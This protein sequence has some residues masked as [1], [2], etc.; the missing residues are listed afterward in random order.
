MKRYVVLLATLWLMAAGVCAQ[1]DQASLERLKNFAQNMLAYNHN[2]TQEKVYLHL[3]NNGYLPGETIWFKAYVMKASSLLPTDMSKVLYVEL[4]NPDGQLIERKTLPVTNGRTYGDFKVDPGLCRPGYYEVRAYTRAMLNWDDAYVFS[5]VVPMYIEPNDTINFSDIKMPPQLYAKT[6]K[7]GLRTEPKALVDDNVITS[8]AALLSFYPEGGHITRG[9][10][11]RVAYKL[12]DRDGLPGP[13]EISICNQAGEEVLKSA[14]FHD[15]MGVFELP[16]TWQ[17][18]TARLLDN[19]DKEHIFDLPTPRPEGADVHVTCTPNDGLTIKILSTESLQGTIAG[20]SVTCRANLL[21]FS[22]LTL[23][24]EN[25]INIP[26]QKLRDGILQISLFT[27]EGKVLSERLVWCA[28][29]ST[30]PTMKI[31]QNQEIYAPFSPVVLDISLNDAEGKPLRGDFSLSVRDA[32]TEFAPEGN[33]MQIEMLM[34]SDLKGYIHKPEFYFEADDATHSQA[35]DL[36]LMVQGWRR[37][38]WQEMAGVKPFELKQPMEDGL[39]FF[40]NVTDT[41]AAGSNLAKDNGLNLNFLITQGGKAKTYDAKTKPDGTFA[42]RLPDF[43]GDCPSVITITNAKDKRVYTNL[44]INR[45]FSPDIKPYEPLTIASLTETQGER[46]LSQAKP[47]LFNW[48][49]TIPD[50]MAN[51]INLKMVTIHGDRV[52]YGY[53][54]G[55]RFSRGYKEEDV[56]KISRFYYNLREELDKYQDEGRDVPTVYEWLAE[57][58]PLFEWHNDTDAGLNDLNPST[59]VKPRFYYR[60]VPVNFIKDGDKKDEGR[61][62]DIHT[63]G[64]LMNEFSSLVIVE[65]DQAIE[66]IYK[67]NNNA[68][69]VTDVMSSANGEAIHGA[70]MFLYSKNDIVQAPYYKRGTRWLTLHGYSRCDEFYSPDYRKSEP[71]TDTDHRRTLYWNPSLTTD[72]SGKANVIFYSN[73][74]HAQRLNINAQ[75]IAVNGQMFEHNTRK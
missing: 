72:E 58:N 10:P 53:R 8:K 22:D 70:T 46:I 41:Q 19:N 34:A 67:G 28:P 32:A 16:D 4:L 68:N 39:L 71:K 3:D 29:H 40:G 38:S 26:Y 25:S 1:D 45:N 30:Q 11:T 20:L 27:P 75:G 50:L 17:G 60:G 5:R 64:Y 66:N 13:S 36:L 59:I 57:V 35:L 44:K 31:A 37:Y 12:T 15:G 55:L 52:Q 7:P 62:P 61:L 51:A 18:G 24:D 74:R 23:Q 63:K 42:L 56:K 49:D 43:W 47:D 65:D 21:Y 2:Y 33:S 54:P 14:V 48:Q 9:L 73:S 69:A 6:K